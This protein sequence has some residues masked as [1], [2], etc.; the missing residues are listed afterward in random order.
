MA[1]LSDYTC[2][3]LTQRG[4]F[5]DFRDGVL[6]PQNGIHPIQRDADDYRYIDSKE[7]Y[8]FGKTNG[9]AFEGNGIVLFTTNA[10]YDFAVQNIYINKTTEGIQLADSLNETAVKLD[11][12]CGVVR[13][14]D[15]FNELLFRPNGERIYTLCLYAD[16]GSQNAFC[17]YKN[18]FVGV[19][20][21]SVL[22]LHDVLYG[23]RPWRALSDTHISEVHIGDKWVNDI[24]G[25]VFEIRKKTTK[26][27]GKSGR[28]ANYTL[29]G[30]ITE[31]ENPRTSKRQGGRIEFSTL[32]HEAERF[33]I[34]EDPFAK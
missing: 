28:F 3:L 22:K 24:T 21:V 9:D 27:G 20:E 18:N 32:H 13:A 7:K 10:S 1:K 29:S 4:V 14:L 17:R 31:G 6:K 25:E 34:H 8:S 16:G 5:F 15:I 26:K 23:R 2:D 11:G 19:N 33:F 30:L 12:D